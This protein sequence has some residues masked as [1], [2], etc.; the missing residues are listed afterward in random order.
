[1][2]NKSLRLDRF[3][4]WWTVACGLVWRTISRRLSF[5]LT[6]QHVQLSLIVQV[7]WAPP[8]QFSLIVQV[9]WAPLS[10]SLALSQV[11]VQATLW[12]SSLRYLITRHASC[13][14]KWHELCT[15][16]ST[17]LV[18][19]SSAKKRDQLHVSGIDEPYG[20]QRV[21]GSRHTKKGPLG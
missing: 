11:V 10:T 5:T 19:T 9:M 2:K 4:V 3:D 8:A 15:L 16:D 6:L 1:M 21:N 20:P 13:M 17:R 14:Y 12:S 7:T 18:R